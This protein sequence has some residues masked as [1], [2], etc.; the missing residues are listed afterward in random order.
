MTHGAGQSHPP[1]ILVD[2]DACPVKDEI[3][4]VAFRH[5]LPVRLFAG[6]YLRHPD[7]ALIQMTM[8][9]DAFD[10]ADDLIA[11]MAGPGCLVITADL[12]LADRA[13]K[14]GAAVLTHRGEGLTATNIGARLATRDLLADLRGGLDGQGL[15]G[16]ALGGPRP[17]SR[18]DRS[19]FAQA[20]EQAARRIKA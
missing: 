10:A 17:F 20:L 6:S 5:K 3:Y 19:A 12:P 2:A 1:M 7:H 18:S 9:G 13:I 4:T 16:H 11:A 15:G 14:A 8:A